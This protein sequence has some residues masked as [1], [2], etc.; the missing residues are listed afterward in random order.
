MREP[1]AVPGFAQAVVEMRRARLRVSADR[2]LRPIGAEP[3]HAPLVPE[4]FEFLCKEAEDLY[5]NELAWEELTDEEAVAGG[6]LTEL[7]FPAF[8]AF[9]DALLAER[10]ASTPLGAS[11]AYPEV[12]ENILT[13]LGERLAGFTAELESGADSQQIVWA[14]AM[15][16][17]LI[18]LVLYRLYGLSPAEQDAVDFVA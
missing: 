18:D 14:R 7:V 8:L 12:V 16:A 5:W 10:I 17:D 3:G 2:A 13:F 11:R 15:T 4:H 6:H 1:A 9:V